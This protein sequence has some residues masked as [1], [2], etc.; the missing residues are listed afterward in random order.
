[1]SRSARRSGVRRAVEHT[2]TV[3]GEFATID[4][5][6]WFE[7]DLAA[8]GVDARQTGEESTITLNHR[9]S[10][11]RCSASVACLLVTA[12]V[13]D[14]IFDDELVATMLFDENGVSDAEVSDGPATL[15]EPV[16]GATWCGTS[17]TIVPPG[18]RRAGTGIRSSLN[19]RYAVWGCTPNNPAHTAIFTHPVKPPSQHVGPVGREDTRQ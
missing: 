6:G 9:P 5:I 13:L 18:K 17:T 4:A 8:V 16:G 7:H 15:A 19:H 1:V 12:A 2:D 10:M 11:S 3:G 14:G